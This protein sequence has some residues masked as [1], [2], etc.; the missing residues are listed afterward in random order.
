MRQVR[1]VSKLEEINSLKQTLS[2]N[3]IA[4]DYVINELNRTEDVFRFNETDK[5]VQERLN[6]LKYIKFSLEYLD[7]AYSDRLK[8]LG[9]RIW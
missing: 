3:D 9:V 4:L 5:D 2:Y 1:K 6:T 8:A 7:K